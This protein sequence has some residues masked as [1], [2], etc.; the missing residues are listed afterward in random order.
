TSQASAFVQADVTPLDNLLLRV[1]LRYDY[2]DP[3]EPIPDDKDNLG[4]RVSFSWAPFEKLRLKGG[5]GRF[6][7]VA[8]T[9]PFL[10]TLR[11]GVD[12]RTQIRALGVGPASLWPTVTWRLPG[13][14]FA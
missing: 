3:I 9:G 11:D 6:F 12:V 5:W 13:R 1:G 10:N 14:R 4:P 7:G 2:E 8:S